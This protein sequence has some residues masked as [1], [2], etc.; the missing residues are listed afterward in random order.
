MRAKGAKSLRREIVARVEVRPTQG[1]N[2]DDELDRRSF[3][4]GDLALL[5][6]VISDLELTTCV[7]GSFYASVHLCTPKRPMT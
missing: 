3:R 5:V 7:A 1:D 4:I 2:W 6:A